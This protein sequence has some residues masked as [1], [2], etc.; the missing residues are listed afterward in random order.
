LIL[1]DSFL[2]RGCAT[3]TTSPTRDKST[4]IHLNTLRVAASSSSVVSL[5]VTFLS[6]ALKRLDA[7]DQ[8]SVYVGCFNLGKEGLN[9]HLSLTIQISRTLAADNRPSYLHPEPG[10]GSTFFMHWQMRYLEWD[11]RSSTISRTPGRWTSTLSPSCRGSC[12]PGTTRSRNSPCCSSRTR[13]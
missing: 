12:A 6:P 11:C 7:G 5:R 4:F 1:P 9:C 3:S 10:H 13:S 2:R 8:S